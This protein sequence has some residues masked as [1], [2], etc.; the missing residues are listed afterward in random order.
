MTHDANSASVAGFLL[1]LYSAAQGTSV[2][3]FPELAL[4]Q[5]KRFVDFDMAM[6]GVISLA[7]DPLNASGITA[8]WGHVHREPSNM[9]E[10]WLSICSRDDVLKNMFHVLGQARSYHAPS[11]FSRKEDA[12][13][14]DFALRTRHLNILAVGNRYVASELRGAFSIRRAD[15]KWRFTARE[16]ALVQMLIPHLWEAIR[17][18]RTVMASQAARIAGSSIKGVCVCD[19]TGM[20][21]FQDAAFERLRL[22]AFREPQNFRIPVELIRA[23]IHQRLEKWQDVRLVYTVRAVARL[24]FITVTLSTGMDKLSVREKQ[25]ADFFGTGLTHAEIADEL[26]IA[27]STVRRHVESIYR[28]LGIGTKADLSFLVH[29]SRGETAAGALV[30]LEAAVLKQGD[31]C[32]E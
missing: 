3:A 30:A 9:V 19:D 10:E 11:A 16:N 2:A 7:P 23:F 26:R 20:I 12:A 29:A 18:N 28:K 17:I 6:M 8:I 5:L 27:G 24:R 1:R 31:R 22:T 4:D 15:P 13:L 14:L 21:L 25:I 32:S